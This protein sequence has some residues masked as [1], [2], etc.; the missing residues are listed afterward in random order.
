HWSARIGW[1][2]RTTTAI[3]GRR[4]RRL[5]GV[6]T[7]AGEPRSR[8]GRDQA[9]GV[10]HPQLAG[11]ELGEEAVAERGEG[12]GLYVGQLTLPFGVHGE[13]IECTYQRGWRNNDQGF[14]DAVYWEHVDRCPVRVPANNVVHP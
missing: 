2:L 11:D 12:A 13:G 4:M 1:S 10:L 6:V 7:C 3:D 8:R 9:L 5:R 14:L